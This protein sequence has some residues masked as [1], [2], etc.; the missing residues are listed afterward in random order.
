VISE[1]TI[2]QVALALDEAAKPSLFEG[3]SG[4]HSPVATAK[5]RNAA[6]FATS[7]RWARAQKNIQ[8]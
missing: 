2:Q 5:L 7:P 8:T 6:D 4:A 3:K 1:Q